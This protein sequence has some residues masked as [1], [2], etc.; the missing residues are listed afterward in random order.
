[1]THPLI[2]QLRFA[3][4]EFERGLGE[5]TG[6]QARQRFGSMNSISWIV[7]H[8]AWQEQRY[9]LTRAQDRILLPELNELLA[10]G[11]PAS[12]PPVEEMWAAWRMVTQSAD[13]WLDAHTTESLQ[14]PLVAG[15]SSVGTFLLRVT[16]HY[17][18]H[19]GEGMAVRQLLGHTGLPD[20]VGDIDSQAPYHSEAGDESIAPIRKEEFAQTLQQARARWE[21]VLA[22][23]DEATMHEPF[24]SQGWTLKDIVAHLAWHDREML[25]LLR[26]R[27]LAGSELWNLSL[28]ERN[29][30]IYEQNRH[31]PLGVVR[32]EAQETYAQL[33]QEI[34]QLSDEDL[35][36]PGRF[37]D[38]PADWRPWQL[39]AE[40]TYLHY[41]DHIPYVKHWL[42]NKRSSLLENRVK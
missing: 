13:P 22:G 38:M 35:H 10:Y 24:G 14:K 32:R 36:D 34:D 20:F 26:Q 1:M 3:R 39:L 25:S 8:L 2:L 27:A 4:S 6:D 23:V 18:Y 11:K 40:N 37:A 42:A 9:W 7:G 41:Q 29:R 5:V 33:L 17:W 28:E 30:A 19:L 31:L 15:F 12:T 16:Y 21:D